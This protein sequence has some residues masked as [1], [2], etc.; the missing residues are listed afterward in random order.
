MKD[1][2]SGEGPGFLSIGKV[3]SPR[4]LKGEV[5][6]SL[7]LH[8]DEWIEKTPKLFVSPKDIS[9]LTE[10]SARPQVAAKNPMRLKDSSL[11]ESFE[12]EKWSGSENQFIFKLKSLESREAAEAIAGRLVFISED[13]F[14]SKKGEPVFLS[15][16]EG[17][18]VKDGL[19]T[20]G[21]I[22]GFSSNGPQDLLVVNCEGR[23]VEIPFVEAFLKE[24][25]FDQK[26][27]QMDLPQGLWQA[28]E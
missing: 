26:I 18:L 1:L 8:P 22:V 16:I 21:P 28:E 5:H 11:L 2:S 4:G 25:L 20:V 6:I 27:V 23:K 10:P 3:R 7:S 17:F 12:I 14:T 9:V 15:E 24:I 13:V 19:E